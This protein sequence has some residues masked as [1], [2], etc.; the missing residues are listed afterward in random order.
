LTDARLAEECEQAMG[1]TGDDAHVIRFQGDRGAGSLESLM[2]DKPAGFIPCDTA[3]DDVAAILFT[4]G[5][6]GRAKGTLHFHRDVLA[7]TDCFPRHVLTPTADDL[8]CGSPSLAFA[9]GMGALL[10]FPLRYGAAALLL[11]QATPPHLLQGIQDYRATIC[12]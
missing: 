6:T 9:Y 1:E 2:R 4:S 7:V 11:E 5:T 10:L 8:F 3:A 12:F